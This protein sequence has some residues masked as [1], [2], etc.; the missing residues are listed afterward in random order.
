MRIYPPRV[1]KPVRF[2]RY[3]PIISL[4]LRF[5]VV[6]TEQTTAEDHLYRTEYNFRRTTAPM[7]SSS[8]IQSQSVLEGLQR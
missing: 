1:S 6:S 3:S 5:P 7:A 4:P 8:G 2:E